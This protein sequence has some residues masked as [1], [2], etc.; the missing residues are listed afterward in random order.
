MLPADIDTLVR[1]T[2]EI[3]PKVVP[4]DD[5]R[6]I[7]V[8]PGEH[9][10]RKLH[11]GLSA[12]LITTDGRSSLT[13]TSDRP[14]PIEVRLHS[15]HTSMR[16]PGKSEVPVPSNFA[17]ADTTVSLM[18]AASE[19]ILTWARL[20]ELPCRKLHRSPPGFDP[21]ATNRLYN[22]RIVDRST[23]KHSNAVAAYP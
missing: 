22:L 20:A 21:E 7:E 17:D 1:W 3:D 23:A 16:A 4:F 8:W 12:R 18:V 5:R 13:I 19:T 9:G 2:A 11:K 14:R 6:F 15:T 10:E